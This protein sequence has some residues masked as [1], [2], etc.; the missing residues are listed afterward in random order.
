MEMGNLEDMEIIWR[1]KKF[2]NVLREEPDLVEHACNPSTREA[3]A[4]R[5]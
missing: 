5:F 4:G 2:K 3:E 1:K